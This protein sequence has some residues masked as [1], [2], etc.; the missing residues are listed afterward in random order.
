MHVCSWYLLWCFRQ[1][2]LIF[3]KAIGQA[4]G[5]IETRELLL[6]NKTNV[7]ASVLQLLLRSLH[8]RSSFEV[9]SSSYLGAAG[10]AM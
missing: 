10:P 6:S 3:L 5:L 4:Q 8:N 1:L 7:G 2:S 9:Q